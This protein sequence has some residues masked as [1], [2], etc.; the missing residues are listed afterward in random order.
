[1]ETF[2]DVP[3]GLTVIQGLGV[4]PKGSK[5]RPHGSGTQERTPTIVNEFVRK[6]AVYAPDKSSGR[7]GQKMELVWTSLEKSTYQATVRL[8]NGKEKAG[9]RDLSAL[10]QL[11][12]VLTEARRRRPF[13]AGASG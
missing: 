2:V 12:Y 1:M 5:R 9:R 3:E 4:L 7:R 6:N 8:R 11:N 13:F 10:R